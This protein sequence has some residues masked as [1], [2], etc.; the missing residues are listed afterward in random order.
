MS[1]FKP[2][3]LERF[4]AKHEFSAKYLL[5]SSDCES[6]PVRELLAMEEGSTDR[7]LELRLGY[8]E[9]RGAPSLRTAIAAHYAGLSPEG[10][11]V[12][13]GAE[14][15]IL[16]LCMALLEKG[17]RVVVNAPCYQSLSEIPRSLGCELVPWHFR[18][19]A[20]QG[21]KPRW[22]LD[23]D[24]LPGLAGSGGTKLIILNAPHNPTGALPTRDEFEAIVAHARR[25]GAVLFVDEVYRRLE[26][27]QE[28]RLPSVCEAYENGVALDVLSKHSGLA[29]LRIGW[30]AS[31]RADILDAV[32]VIKDYNSI[33]ASAPSELIAEIA[34][35]NLEAIAARNR[36]IVARNL[37][38]L[39]GFFERRSGFA[40]WTPPVAGSVAFPHLSDG[41]D[42]ETLA[43]RLVAETG[44][45]LLPGKYYDYD[46]SYFRIGFGRKN[47][48]EALSRLEEWLGQ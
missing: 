16:N 13:S 24:E 28:A 19:T 3:A 39:E 30:L 43:E 14:E 33:C 27:D 20:G 31:K 18:E 25:A 32:A 22:F 5:C 45:L 8:T 2:F 17:D 6:I 42:S 15:A 7:L 12:H 41:S 11:F 23:P 47:M 36:G 34:V 4:F 9:T 26:R 21:G 37:A 40:R 44:V 1:F 29:G 10:V 48:P 35:R 46:S 38:L